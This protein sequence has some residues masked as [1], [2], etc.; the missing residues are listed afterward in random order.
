V[1]AGLRNGRTPERRNE[2]P[3]IACYPGRFETLVVGSGGAAFPLEL[4]GR[5]NDWISAP[6]LDVYRAMNSR[7]IV[8]GTMSRIERY[9]LPTAVREDYL[10][11]Y[12][13]NRFVESM[14]YVRAYPR[15]LEVLGELLPRIE[16]PV[17]IV[18]GLWDSAVPPVNHRY[19]R[20]RLPRSAMSL[21]DAGH[22]TW[23]D[24]ASEYADIVA[25][26]WDGGH[27]AV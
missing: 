17:L 18:G 21:L 13:G 3:V 25:R 12:D 26:W 8:T 9:E 4:G 22:F 24:A 7:Q 19:L 15:E 27:L 16:T 5:L 1:G 11:A 10:S 2:R 23:E 20:D 14:S 6:S